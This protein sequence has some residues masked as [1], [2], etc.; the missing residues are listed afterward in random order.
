MK[1]TDY[2]D[3]I[4]RLNSKNLQNA[5]EVVSLFS[6]FEKGFERE[7]HAATLSVLHC[8]TVRL[9]SEAIVKSKSAWYKT[10][11]LTSKDIPTLLNG[12]NQ[13]M[14]DNRLK[15]EVPNGGERQDMLF[16]L[17][18][19]FSRVAYIQL[20]PQNNAI[21]SLPLCQLYATIE[22]IPKEYWNQ[23]PEA[24]K[25]KI[26]ELPSTI[27]NSL[28][29]SVENILIA[30]IIVCSYFSEKSEA[31]NEAMPRPIN[32]LP[33]NSI[34]ES[35][36]LN[37]LLNN[38]DP[39]LDLFRIELNIFEQK[40]GKHL[41]ELIKKYGKV[42]G[43]GINTHREL[44]SHKEYKIGLNGLRLASLN[45]YPLIEA[46]DGN[47]WYVP[48]IRGLF[49]FFPDALHFTITEQLKKEYEDIKGY[50]LEFYLSQLLKNR[51]TELVVIPEGSWKEKKGEN[52]GSDF[53]IIDHGINP[54][55]IGIEIKSRRMKPATRFLLSDNDLIE[56]YK[57][58]WDAI[59]KM[60][61]KLVKAF[62]LVGDYQK[63]E[64]DLKKAF[65]YPRFYLGIAGETPYLFGELALYLSKKNTEHLL[66]D[67]TE[68][69]AVMSTETFENFIEILFH[70]NRAI[71]DVL[72]EYMED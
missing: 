44:L 45:R 2:K 30:H 18:R 11:K 69:W 57:D 62:S 9:L 24:F 5:L 66:N 29:V 71:A 50:L 58:L 25:K 59:K 32:S 42:F 38:F 33:V 21:L 3:T 61:E 31:I 40:Y 39:Y 26:K 13:A 56:N 15:D 34:W 19:Y 64:D 8:E 27:T 35:K 54:C 14:S 4:I 43:R 28:G 65:D 46:T 70:N 53:I 1:Q 10:D 7:E 36:I 6:C 55:V 49:R 17:Q 63:Y 12:A 67:F 41:R 72:N 51:M 52:K 48:N 22:V 16:K 23:F 37:M 47:T 60:P 20:R 68:P